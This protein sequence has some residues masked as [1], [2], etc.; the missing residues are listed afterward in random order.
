MAIENFCEIIRRIHA[1]PKAK[2]VGLTVRDY[3][4]LQEHVAQCEECTKLTD[5]ILEK[6]KDVPSD[7]NLNDGRYN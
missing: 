7:P 5:E 6:Y 1:D 3:Y 2:V 4:N